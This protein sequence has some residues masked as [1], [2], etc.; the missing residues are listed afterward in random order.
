M[1][2]LLKKPPFLV[3]IPFILFAFPYSS[4]SANP[5]KESGKEGK[6]LGKELSAHLFKD[7]HAFEVSEQDLLPDDDKHK[8]LDIELIT[9]QSLSPQN[10]DDYSEL[11]NVIQ[12][13]HTKEKMDEAEPL[14]TTGREVVKA[15]GKALEIA[16]IHEENI[17]EEEK[18]VTCQEEG[19]YDVSFTQ[20]RKVSIKPAVKVSKEVCE[21]SKKTST[22]WVFFKNTKHKTKCWQEEVVVTPESQEDTWETD[23]LSHLM[24]LQGSPHCQLLYV[25]A[26]GRPETRTIDGRHVFRESWEQ[27]LFFSCTSD[28]DS[29]CIRLQAQGG[30]LLGKKCIQENPLGECDVWEKT[31]EL[32]KKPSH[33][34]ASFAFKEEEIWGLNEEFDTSCEKNGDFGES[35]ATLSV[36]ADI[37]DT[38]EKGPQNLSDRNFQIFKG[39]SLKCSRSFIGGT[40]FDCCHKMEGLAIKTKLAACSSEEKCLAQKRQDGKC[41]RIGSKN[42]TLGTQTEHVFCCYPTKLARIVHEQGKKQL[43]LKWGSPDSPHCQGLSLEELKRIDFSQLDLSEVIEDVQVDKEELVKK[44]HASIKTIQD[45]HAKENPTLKIVQQQK[46]KCEK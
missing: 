43:H 13:S 3:M 9:Q 1:K 11:N 33:K 5:M 12:T 14:F 7:G 36:F 21:S 41:H 18:V 4:L 23:Y 28:R 31:Y 17:P 30:V 6:D 42:K 16:S 40:L 27:E 29:P 45:K 37:E 34:K 15:P 19:N 2:H 46:E 38:L 24:R 20:M 25:R 39:E 44:I 32:G 22:S 10:P 8:T 35:I 26:V